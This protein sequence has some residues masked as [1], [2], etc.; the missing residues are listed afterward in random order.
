MMGGN[1]FYLLNKIRESKFD[2]KLKEAINNGI[3]YVGSSAGSIIL[4]NTIEL[5]LPFDK[6]DVNV[7]DYTGLKLIDGIVVPHANRKQEF[8]EEKRKQ[9]CDKIYAINDGH[10]ILYDNQIREF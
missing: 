4:G 8:I 7:T 2:L 9:F 1:T 5:A 6:N 10:G 3:I